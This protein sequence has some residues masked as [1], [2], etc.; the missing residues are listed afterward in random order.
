MIGPSL[1]APNSIALVTFTWFLLCVSTPENDDALA[2]IQ[3]AGFTGLLM[4]SS[5]IVD[6]PFAGMTFVSQY[7]KSENKNPGM[8]HFVG[9]YQ[10]L[11]QPMAQAAFLPHVIMN[12]TLT[13]DH[14]EVHGNLT[15]PGWYVLFYLMGTLQVV[16]MCMTTY[17]LHVMGRKRAFS[18][19][20]FVLVLEGLGSG[21]FRCWRLFT[22]P[23]FSH[24][25]TW[26]ISCF[27]LLSPAGEVAF[28]TTASM[29]TAYQWVRV[30]SHGD[31]AT[32]VLRHWQSAKSIQSCWKRILREYLTPLVVLISLGVFGITQFTSIQFGMF[33]WWGFL[34]YDE[35]PL[36]DFRSKSL[37]PPI[38]ITAT[39]TAVYFAATFLAM[40]RLLVVARRLTSNTPLIKMV[41]RMLP[42]ILL[43]MTGTSLNL[44][45]YLL[46][47]V[48][49]LREISQGP[50]LVA[51]HI[52]LGLGGLCSSFGTVLALAPAGIR[53]NMGEFKLGDAS[54]VVGSVVE[55]RATEAVRDSTY[56]DPA[57]RRSSLMGHIKR[58]SLN[59]LKATNRSMSRRTQGHR[60]TENNAGHPPRPC[61]QTGCDTLAPDAKMMASGA[62]RV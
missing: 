12:V 52:L 43:T 6:D 21:I 53:K 39:I 8:Q 11:I 16:N 24:L 5:F 49:S 28:S 36:D 34:Y 44:S 47:Y 35:M 25:T 59:Y 48:Y 55:H 29:L 58:S 60:T 41:K 2:D 32:P 62:S 30:T 20:G 61:P 1:L 22:W 45:A 23:H 31:S 19:S 3:R 14:S 42:W 4:T 33:L 9:R 51:C 56:V 18:L 40:H 57:R 27:L 38:V 26:F 46:E 50:V 17:V 15:N 54:S 37:L 7:F 10:D 13:D